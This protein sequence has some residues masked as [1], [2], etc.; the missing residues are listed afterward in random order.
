MWFVALTTANGQ[1]VYGT[2][3][4]S[5]YAIDEMIRLEY[6]TESEVE[7]ADTLA[8]DG[9]AVV[10]GPT[11]G[12][13]ISIVNGT[14]SRCVTFSWLIRAEAPGTIVVASPTFLIDGRK[15]RAEPITLTI[16]GERP[17]GG[18]DRNEYRDDNTN[19]NTDNAQRAI[20]I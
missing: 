12:R 2:T 6:R 19:D 5:T 16:T 8:A 15:Y 4:K 3:E 7:S 13:Q 1:T 11:V 17:S 9:F 20:L 14:T 18:N 10:A